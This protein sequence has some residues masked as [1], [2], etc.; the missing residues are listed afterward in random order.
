MESVDMIASG[1][2]WVCPECGEDNLENYIPVVGSSIGDV[3]C[4]G[5]GETF[6]VG[7]YDHCFSRG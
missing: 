6:S 1:Y 2:E 4:V 5:C 7:S 3:T